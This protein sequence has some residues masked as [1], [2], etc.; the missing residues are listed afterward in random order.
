MKFDAIV[1]ALPALSQKQLEALRATIDGLTTKGGTCPERVAPLYHI[2]LQSLTMRISYKDFTQASSFKIWNKNALPCIEFVEHTWPETAK[3]KVS[4][5][6]MLGL[7]FDIL[8]K[9]MKGRDIPITLGTMIN[10]LGSI[11]ELFDRQFPGY[12]ESGLAQLILTKMKGRGASG[13]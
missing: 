12:R 8:K 11:P 6:A 1:G 2:L 13:E 5:M 9:D 3:S 10:N 7:L 4:K